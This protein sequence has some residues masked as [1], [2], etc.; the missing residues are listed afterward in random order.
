MP[1]GMIET[2]L[3]APGGKIR[4][5]NTHL[6]YYSPLQRRAQV[7]RIRE[8]HREACERA[9]LYQP[10]PELEPPFQLGFR[11][12]TAIYCGDFNFVPDS[13]DYRELLAPPEG[14]A[15]QLVDAWRARHGGMARAP[16][17]GLHGFP[18]PERPDCYDYFFVTE[19]LVPRVAEVNVQS[20]TSASDHQPIVLDLS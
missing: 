1:R 17:A 14:N 10:E 6:E 5:L 2:V 9:R 7:R 19:D 12:C 16:T 13:E 8:L 3:E 11:P 20:E 4:V 15:L 18:W